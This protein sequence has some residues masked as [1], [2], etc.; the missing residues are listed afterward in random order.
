[1]KKNLIT[2]II[3]ALCVVN[4]ILNILLVF[5]CICLLYTSDAADE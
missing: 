3:L 5:V 1:M 4:L 2:V